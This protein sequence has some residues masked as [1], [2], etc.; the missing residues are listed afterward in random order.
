MKA[1][2]SEKVARMLFLLKNEKYQSR[3]NEVSA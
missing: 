3:E 1:T 2:V